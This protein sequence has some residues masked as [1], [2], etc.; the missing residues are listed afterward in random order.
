MVQKTLAADT[1]TKGTAIVTVMDM[2]MDMVKV[3][4]TDPGDNFAYLVNNE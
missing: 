3:T 2:D 4:D 1:I